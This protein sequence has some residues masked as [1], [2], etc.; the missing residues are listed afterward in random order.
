[1]RHIHSCKN[2][3]KM[4]KLIFAI[5]ASVLMT[6]CNLLGD[7]MG[8]GV[9]A[10]DLPDV[11]VISVSDVTAVVY[12]G[13]FDYELMPDLGIVYSTDPSQG[14]NT[15]S[16]QVTGAGNYN[17]YDLMPETTYY[18]CSY[19]YDN[20]GERQLGKVVQFT[21]EKAHPHVEVVYCTHYDQS[22]IIALNAW[23]EG[24]ATVGVCWG[25]NYD[26]TIYSDEYMEGTYDE[27]SGYYKVKVSGLD[28]NSSY[29]YRGYV[30]DM[31]G[32]V[33]YT[34]TSEFQTDSVYVPEM[35]VDP[36]KC[37]DTYADVS[38][39]VYE[40]NI[41]RRGV[42]WSTE[43]EPT[44]DDFKTEDVADGGYV[45]VRLEN[46]QPSTLYYIRPYVVLEHE[47]EGEVLYYGW[48]AEFTTYELDEFFEIPDARFAEYL[49]KFDENGDGKL[50][51]R[52]AKKINMIDISSTSVTSLQGIEYCTN[53]SYLYCNN[54]KIASIDLS[55]N[56][57]LEYVQ[58]E[59][60]N[61]GELKLGEHPYMTIL[62]C[63]DNKLISLDVSKAPSL[64][65]LACD[66][67]MLRSLDLSAN[68]ELVGVNCGNNNITSLDLSQ[69]KVL[70]ELYC[71]HMKLTS[72]NVAGLTKLTDILCSNN[73][74][75]S[76]IDVTG[77]VSLDYLHCRLCNLT[78]LDLS[79]NTALTDL[80]CG[81][82]KT[83]TELNISGCN[84]LVKFDC[85][86]NKITTLDLSGRTQLSDVICSEN[87]LTELNVSGCS[88]LKK[89]QCNSNKIKTLDVSGLAML[90]WLNCN[91]NN[92]T[93]L[94]LSGAIR[95]L[96]LY[97]NLNSLST[98][99]VSDCTYL[100]DLD[101]G[102]NNITYL[103]LRNNLDLKSSNVVCD[104]YVTIDWE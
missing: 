103:D 3:L 61:L 17:L 36:V 37:G 31:E 10:E 6:S 82:N 35:G 73:E 67:N 77:C 21:T 33:Y 60:S 81:Y 89:L 101:C 102:R 78:S 43:P 91:Y 84:K 11:E 49:L 27:D 46:L 4:R 97:C 76:T 8:G 62:A 104:S 32:N 14:N 7:I 18:V 79:T 93:S 74:D 20:S 72:L 55:Q 87:N 41:I 26:P 83:I 57:M 30:T 92:L 19:V 39:F 65:R 85:S 75:L 40:E 98:L 13:D 80:D 34:E 9:V 88:S 96:N 1:M 44:I 50:S 22:F 38:Y 59:N 56:R 12:V 94:N 66:N 68:T 28:E 58:C 42:C 95:L 71:S 52:E 69:N 48:D 99:D 25:N 15:C 51:I 2:V 47:Y 53:L 23:G 64:V 16:I 63:G 86:E 5:L 90:E 100:I 24:L 70:E 54:N 45:N 29:C